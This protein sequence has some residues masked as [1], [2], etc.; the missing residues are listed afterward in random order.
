[1][2]VIADIIEN[3]MFLHKHA[4]VIGSGG[5]IS[6]RVGDT[7][8]IKRSGVDMS[9]GGIS[10]YISIPF[11]REIAPEISGVSSEV[12]IHWECYKASEDVLAVAHAHSPYS[13]AAS[14]EI[15]E[16]KSPSYE[17]DCLVGRSCPVIPYIQPGSHDLGKA[18]AEKVKEGNSSVILKRH[19]VVAVGK[20]L[21]EACLRLL[22]IERACMVL[23]KS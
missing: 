18:V 17:F 13:V 7:F 5:N 16:L 12:L 1:M 6:V 20:N 15:S 19:G 4:L 10:G 9:R 21:S 23:R 11:S 3:G 22:A 2:G 14:M 8:T